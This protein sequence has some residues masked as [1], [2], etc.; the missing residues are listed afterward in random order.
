MNF[1]IVKAEKENANRIYFI[2]I[3]VIVMI[4][5]FFFTSSFTLNDTSNLKLSEIGQSYN[6]NNHLIEIT[7]WDYSKNS[8]IMEVELNINNTAYDGF[9][10]YMFYAKTNPANKKV[11]VTPIIEESNFV[12]LHIENISKDF[13]ELSLQIMIKNNEITNEEAPSGILKL[14]TNATKVTGVEKIET[15]TKAEYMVKNIE[16]S[17][18]KITVDIESLN[19]S[20]SADEAKTDNIRQQIQK[21]EEDKAY[22]T[23]EQ[24][25]ATNKAI[26]ENERK[27]AL[28][29]EEIKAFE[30]QINDKKIEIVN[31][32]KKI[33]DIKAKSEG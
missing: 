27:V 28:I 6:L 3:T 18:S 10:K 19:N 1:E 4:Y 31:L 25:E 16:K 21:Y 26:Q 29:T 13:K 24:L 17:I 33:A 20:I 8:N 5:L 2:V 12:V 23:V 22:Q 9:D 11:V 15:L 30:N 14:Y 32:Q 7:R